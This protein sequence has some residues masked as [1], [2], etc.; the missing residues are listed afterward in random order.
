MTSM[1]PRGRAFFP[2]LTDWMDNPWPFQRNL[3]R[4]EETVEGE[5]YIVRAELPGFDPKEH[6]HVTTEGTLLT[7]SAER[8]S[9]L[10][11]SGQSEF[12]YG[13]FSRTVSLPEGADTS[14]IAASYTDGI[15]E[16][17]VPIEKREPGKPVQIKV[18]SA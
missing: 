3:V 1:M 5:E 11:E 14:K 7:I 4:I 17:T 8:E 9:R 2:G 6:I 10:K 16:V 13:S 18:T 15:L 12:R